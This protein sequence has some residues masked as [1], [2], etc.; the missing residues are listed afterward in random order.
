MREV[1][2]LSME[3]LQARTGRSVLYGEDQLDD[4]S[5]ICLTVTLDSD[6]GGATFDFTGTGPQVRLSNTLKSSSFSIQ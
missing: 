4:G 3:Y 1:P 6:T 2:P 5:P